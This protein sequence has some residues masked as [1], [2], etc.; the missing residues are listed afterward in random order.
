MRS[1]L[2]PTIGSFL[3][4]GGDPGDQVIILV[5]LWGGFQLDFTRDHSGEF[6]GLD[7]ASQ[8]VVNKT[9]P[10]GLQVRCIQDRVLTLMPGKAAYPVPALALPAT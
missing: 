7:T 10:D 6:S 8:A 5:I 9:K 2:L 4:E 3:K 1:A